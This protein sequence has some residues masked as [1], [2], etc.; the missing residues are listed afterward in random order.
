MA[1]K[2]NWHQARWLLYLS[3]S[4]F[5]LH[6][7]L[8]KSMGKLD[9]LLCCVDHSNGSEDNKDIVLLHPDLFTIHALEALAFKGEEHDIHD[10]HIFSDSTNALRQCLDVS[11]H[12]GQLSSLK[13]CEVLLPWLRLHAHHKV[14]FHHITSG[15][16]MEDH[17]LAHIHA[18][19]TRVEAG[20]SP[21]ITADFACYKAVIRMLDGWKTLFHSRKYIGKNFLTLYAKKDT[22]LVPTHV[23]SGPW[24]RKTGYSHTLTACMVRCITGHAPIGEFHA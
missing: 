13:A 11:H 24:M 17:Q 3:H 7:K 8:G 15:V 12:S 4:N 6:H 22:P 23:N 9:T 20:E 14:H 21:V 18:V 16:E 5:M 1:Q 2:L 19:S 10:I